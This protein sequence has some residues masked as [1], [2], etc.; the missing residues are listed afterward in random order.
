MELAIAVVTA[1]VSLAGMGLKLWL[2]HKN[3]KAAQAEIE[4]WKKLAVAAAKENST[5][6]KLMAEK[7]S[8]LVAAQTALVKRLSAGEL[9]ARLDELF[10]GEPAPAGNPA[11]AGRSGAT[12]R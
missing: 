12:P 7:E 3:V 5:L 6:R 10:G 8:Q 2:Q 11:P 9:A 1:V 4:Q